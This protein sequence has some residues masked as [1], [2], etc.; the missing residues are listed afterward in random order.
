LI[1][2]KLSQSQTKEQRALTVLNLRAC[3][4]FSVKAGGAG[5]KLEKLVCASRQ[6]AIQDQNIPEERGQSKKRSLQAFKKRCK[7]GVEGKELLDN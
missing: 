6:E 7:K 4:A 5:A 3:A 2:S 1:I